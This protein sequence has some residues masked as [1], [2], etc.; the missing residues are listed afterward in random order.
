M[1]EYLHYQV[2]IFR[3]LAIA[4][5]LAT[6]LLAIYLF[7]EILSYEEARDFSNYNDA[8]FDSERK[9]SSSNTELNSRSGGIS[10]STKGKR[11][12]H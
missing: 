12:I 3:I 2:L 11:D 1:I 5:T 4:T 6:A 7:S 10:N 9:K 8:I